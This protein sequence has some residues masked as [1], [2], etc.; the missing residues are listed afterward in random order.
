MRSEPT[1]TAGHAS[2]LTAPA[3]TTQPPPGSATGDDIGLSRPSESNAEQPSEHTP[4]ETMTMPG[5]TR[6]TPTLRDDHQLC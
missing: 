4:K 1:G 2:T 5:P 6:Q 3:T